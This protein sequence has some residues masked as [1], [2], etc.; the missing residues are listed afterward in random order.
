MSCCFGAPYFVLQ[1][2][3]DLLRV[4]TGEAA[5]ILYRQPWQSREQPCG[6]GAPIFAK[7]RGGVLPHVIFFFLDTAWSISHALPSLFILGCIDTLIAC[8]FI[9]QAHLSLP[10]SLPS[11]SSPSPPLSPH[12][13]QHPKST[14]S[15]L[16]YPAS[17]PP[18]HLLPHLS[19]TH[20]APPHHDSS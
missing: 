10:V 12:P 16:Q 18:H 8:L 11:P 15:S 7:A 3:A 6:N 17:I 2:H 4:E 14:A 20:K 9:T 5:R 19:E 1:N 13:D